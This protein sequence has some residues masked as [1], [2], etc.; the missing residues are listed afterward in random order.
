M[1]GEE[2]KAD[3]FTP[4]QAPALPIMHKRVVDI[5]NESTSEPSL[6]AIQL[7]EIEETTSPPVDKSRKT[8]CV[9]S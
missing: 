1:S 8:G 4:M 6:H 9:I 3:K 5:K 7:N 2:M